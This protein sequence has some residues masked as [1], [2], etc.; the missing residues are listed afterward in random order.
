M[1]VNALSGVKLDRP[2][3]EAG[4]YQQ[5]QHIVHDSAPQGPVTKPL[6]QASTVNTL[7]KQKA[8]PSVVSYA[9]PN[10]KKPFKMRV[11]DGIGNIA[12]FFVSMGEMTKATFKAIGGA[13]LA[14]TATMGAFWA[15][16]TLPKAFQQGKEMLKE[17]CKHPIKNTSKTGKVVAGV[18]AAGVATY[19]IIKGIL[20][21]NMRTANVDHALKTGHRDV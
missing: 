6:E 2:L 11:I 15:F 18:A 8:H 7:E 3:A 1:S 13:A 5:P 9:D 20:T 17:V 4:V 16:G 10:A 12:K 21:M 19:H 14:G